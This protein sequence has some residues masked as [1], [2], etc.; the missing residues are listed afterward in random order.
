MEIGKDINGKKVFIGDKVKRDDG[1]IGC[2]SISD[3]GLCFDYD[4]VQE[5][6][7]TRSYV[8]HG[9]RYEL[10]DEYKIINLIELK[11]ILNTFDE[12]D[13]DGNPC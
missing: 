4:E 11:G 5:N 3:F 2:F 7:A 10:V 1:I 12:Y 9:R 8:N 6:G 13:N